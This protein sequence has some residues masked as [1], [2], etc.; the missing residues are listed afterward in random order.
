MTYRLECAANLSSDLEKLVRATARLEYL[1]MKDKLQKYLATL[2]KIV[3]MLFLLNRKKL[4]I[5]SKKVSLIMLDKAEEEE[6]TH[7]GL[8]RRV[9][10]IQLV[11]LLGSVILLILRVM[12]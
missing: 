4:I 12:F 9:L 2:S 7:G 5:L 3:Q 1:D 6:E 11:I 10:P 8:R